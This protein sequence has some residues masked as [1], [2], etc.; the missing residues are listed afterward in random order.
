MDLDLI[1]PE[2]IGWAVANGGTISVATQIAKAQTGQPWSKTVIAFSVLVIILAS[3]FSALRSPLGT[4]VTVSG[5]ALV[6]IL[7][8]P[9]YKRVLSR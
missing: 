6:V 1:K 7:L 8:W 5:S 9:L 4:V 3:G 2:F